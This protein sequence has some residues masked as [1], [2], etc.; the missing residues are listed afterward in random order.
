MT[1]NRSRPTRAV[2]P[3]LRTAIATVLLAAVLA[4][5][6]GSASPA[7]DSPDGQVITSEEGGLQMHIPE[8]WS[9]RRDLNPSAALQAGNREEEAYVLVVVDPREFF[10][11]L[12][13]GRFADIEIQRFI[14][15]V[16]DP[17][18]SGPELTVVGD[19]DALQYEIRGVVDE[20]NIVYLYT[21]AETSDRFLKIVTWSL[22]SR[23]VEN[24][25]TMLEVTKS[26]R[27]LEPLGDIRPSPLE[28]AEGPGD[29]SPL[30]SIDRGDRE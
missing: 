7:G 8:S 27:Q 5:C 11:D 9:Q 3:A 28:P 12:T 4:G 21:L 29:P 30:P 2:G 10:E 14:D 17:E 1:S 24:R 25:E 13:L 19:A 22:G 6:S 18:V 16:G 26:V 15:T 20:Q 23:Y